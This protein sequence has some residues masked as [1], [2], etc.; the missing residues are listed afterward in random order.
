MALIVVMLRAGHKVGLN[1]G[2][3]FVAEVLTH[4][5]FVKFSGNLAD[6]AQGVNGL[7]VDFNYF[8]GAYTPC[9]AIHLQLQQ[10]TQ[11]DPALAPV[12]VVMRGE[13]SI[14]GNPQQQELMARIRFQQR[15]A[16]PGVGPRGNS[17]L[18]LNSLRGHSH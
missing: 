5:H 6:V 12:Q 16:A 4:L 2:D 7:F 14:W 17:W 13:P 10:T 8:P 3:V 11:N 1:Q 18:K 9:I 15:T